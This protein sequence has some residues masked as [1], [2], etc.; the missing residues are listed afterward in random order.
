MFLFI[1]FLVWQANYWKLQRAR[2]DKKRIAEA[3]AF[4]AARAAA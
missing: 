4:K 3:K 1:A 2:D